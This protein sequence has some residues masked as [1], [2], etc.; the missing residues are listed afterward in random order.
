MIKSRHLSASLIALVGLASFSI[1]QAQDVELNDADEALVNS[2][3]NTREAIQAQM[4]GLTA[5]EIQVMREIYDENESA[6]QNPSP[7]TVS[8]QITI[9]ERGESPALSIMER[10]DT[11]LVFADRHGNP[12]EITTYRISDDQAATLLPLHSQDNQKIVQSNA[13]SDGGDSITPVQTADAGPIKGLIVT[14]N[15]IMR[16]TNITIML[17]GETFPIV[18]S[19]STRST[20][21]AEEALAF[22]QEMRLSW[23]STMP[24]AQA[25]AGKFS[26]SN[27]GGGV[28]SQRMVSLV[29]GVPDSALEP[30]ALKGEASSQVSL[31]YDR[32][33]EEWYLRLA[34]HIEPWNIS[35]ADRTNDGLRGFSVIRLNGEPPRL[36]G[37][38]VNGQYTTVEQES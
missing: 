12:M 4:P 9:L 14:P 25:L 24:E 16:S 21:D 8:N 30:V 15:A 7:P 20:R 6:R 29:Q 35:I 28:L 11:T 32:E 19:L 26:G 36:I 34:E 13:G 37:L 3:Q 10:Y 31:W 2:L 22:I 17:R 23:A 5:E 38:S 33:K 1:S 27:N 18:L